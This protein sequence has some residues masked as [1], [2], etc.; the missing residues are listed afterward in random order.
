MN[1]LRTTL[2][3]TAAVVALLATTTAGCGSDGSAH[4]GRT[5]V[6]GGTGAPVSCSQTPYDYALDEKDPDGTGIV[7]QRGYVRGA[8]WVAC[9][10]TPTSFA[11]TVQLKRNGLLYGKGQDYNG[12]PNATGHPVMVFAACQ[13]G[14][15][16]LQ[17]QYR[18]T[19]LGGVQSDLTTAP[20]SETVTQ[21]DCDS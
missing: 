14:V 5:L 21:H 12:I 10:G 11:I 8:I 15:Y 16:R 9:T 13:P 2:T 19:A 18:W 4:P 17:Y 3:A 20:I 6:V 1:R 7:V